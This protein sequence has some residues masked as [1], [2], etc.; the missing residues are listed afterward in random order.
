MRIAILGATG[1]VGRTMLE[2]LDE[3]AFPVTELVPL[4]SERSR[5]QRIRWRGQEWEVG[6][7]EPG[8][9]SGCQLALFSAGGARSREW[10]PVAAAEGAVVVDNSSA[11]RLDP[12]VPLVVPEVNA[13]RIALR[14]RGV[15]ANPNCVTI[16]VVVALEALR[17]AAGLRRVV[18]SSYQAVSGAG[19]EGLDALAAERAGTTSTTSPFPAPIDR[20]VIPLIGVRDGDGWTDEEEKLRHESRKILELPTLEVAATCVRVPV[21]VG[22]SASVMVELEH[23][24]PLDE[25]RAALRAMP[26]VQLA[27]GQPPLPREGAGSDL[28]RVGRLR[29]DR[30]RPDVLHF[31]VVADNLRKGAAT[32]AVQIAET[33]ARG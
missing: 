8:V 14:P 17:R 4:A 21:E 11:W 18:V 20:N 2:V 30:D 23:P 19:Q 6:V 13:H 25:A 31:W 10:A 27:E 16:Q 9:F 24:L 33:L 5:G 22:H 12:E 32:N 28:V 15:I 29:A 1:A 7:P 3:R 26:G